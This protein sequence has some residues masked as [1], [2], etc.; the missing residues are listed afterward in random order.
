M[1]R[2]VLGTTDQAGVL[3]LCEMCVSRAPGSPQC[4]FRLANGQPFVVLVTVFKRYQNDLNLP[5][6][7]G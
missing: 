7:A 5:F 3:P 1:H 2:L 4:H 6:Q